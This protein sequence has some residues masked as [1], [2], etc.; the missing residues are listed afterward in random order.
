MES[1]AETYTSIQER[2]PKVAGYRQITWLACKQFL[3]AEGGPKIVT[4]CDQFDQ[5]LYPFCLDLIEMS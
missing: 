5:L 4:L 2:A 3:P 1:L